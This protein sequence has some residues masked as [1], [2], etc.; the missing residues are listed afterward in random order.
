[1]IESVG[2]SLGSIQMAV[3]SSQH[4]PSSPKTAEVRMGWASVGISAEAVCVR[5]RL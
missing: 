4:L 5:Q 1:M 2:L 3:L